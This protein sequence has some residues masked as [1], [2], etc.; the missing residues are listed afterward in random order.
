MLFRM[1]FVEVIA[2]LLVE[3]VLKGLAVNA[4][5]V[6]GDNESRGRDESHLGR[7]PRAEDDG[8]VADG[9]LLHKPKTNDPEV[10]HSRFGQAL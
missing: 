4:L 10:V 1:L 7:G 9:E 8:S 6:E 2:R 5:A 3:A